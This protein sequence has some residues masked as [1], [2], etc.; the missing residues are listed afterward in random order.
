MPPHACTLRTDACPHNAVHRIRVART[1]ARNAAP[2]PSPRPRT[3]ATSFATT[4]A[5]AAPRR[6]TSLGCCSSC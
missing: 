6:S 3:C 2:P 1:T 5:L 4:A